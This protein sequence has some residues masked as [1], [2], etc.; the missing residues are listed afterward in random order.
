MGICVCVY[1]K[2]SVKSF[3]PE[4]Q[5]Q[6]HHKIRLCMVVSPASFP[7]LPRSPVLD[8][9]IRVWSSDRPSSLEMFVFDVL[10]SLSWGKVNWGSTGDFMGTPLQERHQPL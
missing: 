4:V 5:L 10:S 8:K 6:K 7:Y 1:R 2:S 3:E 9:D